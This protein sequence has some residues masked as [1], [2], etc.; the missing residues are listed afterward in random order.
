[1]NSRNLYNG[2]EFPDYIFTENV[3]KHVFFDFDFLFEEPFW[4]T[5][6]QILIEKR[7]EKIV[8]ENIRPEVYFKEEIKVIE[9]PESYTEIAN[10]ERIQDYFSFP[11]SLHMVTE[12]ALIYPKSDDHKFCMVLNR[13]FALCIVGFGINEDLNLTNLEMIEDLRGYLAFLFPKGFP[14]EFEY[15]L[16]SNWLK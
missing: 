7:I 14:Q 3:G 2:K 4:K 8:V 13:E 11:A 12:L 16:A 1:M 5:F 15:K 9:L 10:T 6:K